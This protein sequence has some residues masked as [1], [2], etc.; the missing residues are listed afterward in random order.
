MPKLF[1]YNQ[2]ISAKIKIETRSLAAKA[3]WM[4]VTSDYPSSR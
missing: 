2:C 1:P 3:L 4:Y